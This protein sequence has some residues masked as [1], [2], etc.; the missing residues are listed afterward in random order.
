MVEVIN[1]DDAVRVEEPT[2]PSEARAL[3]ALRNILTVASFA[4]HIGDPERALHAIEEIASR[5]LHPT[6][7]T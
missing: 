4:G 3:H 5:A 2:G 1:T 7:R 6:S